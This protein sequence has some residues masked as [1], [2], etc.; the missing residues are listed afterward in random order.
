MGHLLEQTNPF[1]L[2]ANI[3]FHL[4]KYRENRVINELENNLYVDDLLSGTDTVDEACR[5]VSDA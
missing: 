4:K 2:N 5:L 3:K 1:L